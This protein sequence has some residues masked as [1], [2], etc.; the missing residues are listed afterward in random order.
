[1]VSRALQAAVDRHR[2]WLADLGLPT[3]EA[4]KKQLASFMT[5]SEVA[6]LNHATD[7]IITANAWVK[8]ALEARRALTNPTYVQVVL[9]DLSE[10]HEAEEAVRQADD[11]LARIAKGPRP[12]SLRRS[13]QQAALPVAESEDDKRAV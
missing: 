12:L 9:G 2:W 8:S 10:L 1:M 11:A 6:A 4:D 7:S 5:E 3:W 13:R